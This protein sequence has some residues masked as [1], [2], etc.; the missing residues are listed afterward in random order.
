MPTLTLPLAN[1]P[2]PVWEK[3]QASFYHYGEGGDSDNHIHVA[4]SIWK[5]TIEVSSVSIKYMGKNENLRPPMWKNPL[6]DPQS[7]PADHPP[8]PLREFY[9]KA[10]REAGLIP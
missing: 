8:E 1:F 3:G 4:G 7:L 5:E 10:L 2:E 9:F 6:F